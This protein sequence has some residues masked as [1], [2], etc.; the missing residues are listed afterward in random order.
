VSTFQ[1]IVTSLEIS[2]SSLSFAF[3][4]CSVYVS[5]TVRFTVADQLREITGFSV[6][7]V[8]GVSGSSFDVSFAVFVKVFTLFFSIN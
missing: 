5:H 6:S 1:V 4:H 2:Q 8:S 3:A 7:G